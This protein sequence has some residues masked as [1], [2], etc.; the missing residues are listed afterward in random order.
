[1]KNTIKKIAA[2]AIAF[3]LLGTSTTIAKSINPDSTNIIVA[4]AA[5]K[6]KE[7]YKINNTFGQLVFVTYLN[8]T[9]DYLKLHN[10]TA[11][12]NRYDVHKVKICFD[13]SGVQVTTYLFNVKSIDVRR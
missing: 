6:P 12:M 2:I 8:G 13:V 9:K 10:L 11:Y 1:M 4:N 3:T 5:N 7:W